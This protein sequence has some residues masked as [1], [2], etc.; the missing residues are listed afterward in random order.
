MK[1]MPFALLFDKQI[2]RILPA[3]KNAD[4]VTAIDQRYLLTILLAL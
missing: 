4:A 2:R 1:K 3:D